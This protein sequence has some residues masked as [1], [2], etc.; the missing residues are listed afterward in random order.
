MQLEGCLRSHYPE[1]DAYNASISSSLIDDL[2]ACLLSFVNSKSDNMSEKQYR[3][4]CNRVCASLVNNLKQKLSFSTLTPYLNSIVQRQVMPTYFDYDSVSNTSE[5]SDGLVEGV[6]NVALVRKLY[7]DYKH[8]KEVNHKVFHDITALHE[9]LLKEVGHTSNSTNATNAINVTTSKD[10]DNSDSS[11][12]KDIITGNGNAG[13]ASWSQVIAAADTQEGIDAYGKA[14]KVMGH[15]PWVA[16]GHRWIEEEALKHFRVSEEAHSSQQHKRRKVDANDDTV[17]DGAYTA[18]VE[19]NLLF[20]ILYWIDIGSCF[21]P[22]KRVPNTQVV[23]LDLKPQSSDV[24]KCDFLVASV[25]KNV[26]G[27]SETKYDG[28]ECLQLNKDDVQRISAFFVPRLR[29]CEGLPFHIATLSLV[30]CYIPVPKDRSRILLKAWQ[31]LKLGGSI[32]GMLCIQEKFSIFEKKSNVFYRHWLFVME[33]IG[34]RKHKY[35]VLDVNNNNSGVH[36]SN[37]TSSSNTSNTKNGN[38]NVG[39]V[40]KSH[41]LSFVKTDRPF[42]Q[43]TAV[44][45]KNGSTC[46][47]DTCLPPLY[48]RQDFHDHLDNEQGVGNK[49]GNN[50]GDQGTQRDEVS[51]KVEV[52]KRR[53]RM[54]QQV[55][56][57][58][59]ADYELDLD[60]LMLKKKSTPTT[61]DTLTASAT[62]NNTKAIE[63]SGMTKRKA[64]AS[65][66]EKANTVD[67]IVPMRITESVKPVVES[68]EAV[69]LLQTEPVVE[70]TE[71][72]KPVKA[73]PWWKNDTFW[74][75]KKRNHDPN[76]CACCD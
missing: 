29:P 73:K 18:D 69:K 6:I 49:D 10:S 13:K 16:H 3:S 27:T 53:L 63:A 48:I 58:V 8:H 9:K 7:N 56:Q 11:D 40:T 62:G 23:A 31:L 28:K 30:L 19:D 41:M 12:A 14:A 74:G 52:Y 37:G 61:T 70:S 55:A 50:E 5:A 67:A 54:L 71:A 2:Y 47:C 21:N 66:K 26:N 60:S 51:N 32:E 25:L 24:Y 44:C 22:H 35:E 42:D 76:F 34:F 1:I 4:E 39:R 75:A 57:F 59:S 15:K 45:N 65:Q 36:H 33:R 72:V 17:R 20:P 68:T 38:A 64:S 46:E 43:L